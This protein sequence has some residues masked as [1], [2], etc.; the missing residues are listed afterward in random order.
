[1]SVL[2]FSVVPPGAVVPPENTDPTTGQTSSGS[3]ISV[4]SS[5][6][7]F[8]IS[9]LSVALGGGNGVQGLRLLFGQTQSTGPN[10]QVSM[11]Q[12]VDSNGNPVGLFA[13]G[14]I[15]D[16]ALSV[17]PTY[18]DSV[19]LIPPPNLPADGL[20]ITPYPYDT[21]TGTPTPSTGSNSGSDANAIPEPWSL[22]LWSALTALGLARARFYR[23]ARGAAAV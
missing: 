23:R 3:P 21:S 20:V 8:D 22:T 17:D 14:A 13:P 10:G 11:Q 7:G 2:D 19:Q 1:I 4:L 9:K 5:S 15:L 18:A 6:T 16:F 12:D